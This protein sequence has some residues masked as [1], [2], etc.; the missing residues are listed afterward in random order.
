MT[1]QLLANK[2]IGLDLQKLPQHVAVIMDGNG[3]WAK[4]RGL[5]RIEGHRQGANTLK[6]IL[7]TCNDCGINTLTAYAFSTENWGRPMTEVS[8][9]MTLFEKLLRKELAEMHQEEVC[10][11]FIGDLDPLPKTLQREI[12]RAMDVTK[13]NTGVNFNVAINYGGRLEILKACKAIA[14]RVAQGNL[15]LEA[16]NEATISDYLDTSASPDPDLLIRTSGEMRLSN[17]LLWQMAYAEI[18][19]TDTFWPDFDSSEF[20]KAISDF[21]KRD[22]RF[23]KLTTN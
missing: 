3:R 8:F 22:R 5:P 9:L 1:A 10:I 23:G 11:R 12:D 15:A 21:Q 19:V 7:R 6:A 17:F 18:Y 13:N 14:N 2:F 16:I 20:L 4:Q